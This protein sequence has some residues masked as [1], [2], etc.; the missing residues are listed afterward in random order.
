MSKSTKKHTEEKSLNTITITVYEDSFEVS[1]SE[2]LDL[3]DLYL[4]FSGA[5]DYLK[6]LSYYLETNKNVTVH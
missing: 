4:V 1:A 2:G 5:L 3:L 6:E